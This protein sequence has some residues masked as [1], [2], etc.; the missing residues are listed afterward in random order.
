M[1]TDRSI[2]DR[3]IA[4]AVDHSEIR[5]LQDAYADI[6]TRRRWDELGEVFLDTTVLDLDLRDATK[7]FVGPPAIG[8][9]I[10]GALRQFE[11]FQFGI[12][13]TRIH[14]RAG[15]DDDAAAGRMYMT[16]LR[17]T[18]DGHWSQ[19]YGVYHD[20]FARVDGRWWFAHRTYHSLARRDLPA[21]V[22]DFPHHL[23]LDALP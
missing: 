19:I 15:G 9:F 17:Q 23:G 6:V 13:G 2:D 21:V 5:R 3:R 1:A 11:F 12:L 16:E 8:D 14:L 20:R 22:F 7:R 18:A 4:D 10:E